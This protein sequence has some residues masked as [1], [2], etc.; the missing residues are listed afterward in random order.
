MVLTAIATGLLVR[1]LQQGK[2]ARSSLHEGQ[3]QQV[4]DQGA[5]LDD[6]SV[7]LTSVAVCFLVCV[8]PYE[9]LFSLYFLGYVSCEVKKVRIH[10]TVFPLINS[11]VNFVL[12]FWKLPPF[13]KD[14]GKLWC[15]NEPHLT[16][17]GQQ[18]CSVST[19]QTGLSQGSA[20]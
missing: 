1:F 3:S 8:V 12:Y 13:R 5:E 2:Q 6:L 18:V 4:Q 11:S 19:N 17:A 9:V 20:P 10:A 16:Q 14:V 7:C 15:H